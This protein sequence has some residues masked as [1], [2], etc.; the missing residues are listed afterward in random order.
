M[1]NIFHNLMSIG[2][3]GNSAEDPG[4]P[5]AL[6]TLPETRDQRAEYSDMRI[7]LTIQSG[8]ATMIQTRLQIDLAQYAMIGP[9]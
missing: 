2:S 1:R 4:I 9:V 5:D 3:L 6:Y 7:A 8:H